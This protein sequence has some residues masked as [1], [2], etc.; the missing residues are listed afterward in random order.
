MYGGIWIGTQGWRKCRHPGEVQEAVGVHVCTR[1][2]ILGLLG[3]LERHEP[4]VRTYS[5]NSLSTLIL[6]DP[7][8]PISG[9]QNRACLSAPHSGGGDCRR[10]NLGRQPRIAE[11]PTR[12]SQEALV[13]RVYVQVQCAR[14]RVLVDECECASGGWARSGTC[15]PGF[16]SRDISQQRAR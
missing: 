6:P 3:R 10:V 11:P 5:R 12:L 2:R 16:E 7:F 14:W 8:P 1:G 9:L 15:R 13:W 4:R